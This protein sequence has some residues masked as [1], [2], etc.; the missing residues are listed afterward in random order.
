MNEESI[1]KLESKIE[2]LIDRYRK[3]KKENEELKQKNALVY[4]K[5]EKLLAK[6]ELLE[7]GDE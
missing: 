5:L 3:M 1:N 2:N 6:I 7:N 4:E